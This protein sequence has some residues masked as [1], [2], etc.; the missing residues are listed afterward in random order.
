LQLAAD[1]R[2]SVTT[3]RRHGGI[4]QASQ[5]TDSKDGPATLS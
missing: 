2:R 3:L 4:G 1:A 5:E